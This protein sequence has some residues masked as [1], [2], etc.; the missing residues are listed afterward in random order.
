MFKC[1]SSAASGDRP[2]SELPVTKVSTST[3]VL[4]LLVW[5]PFGANREQQLCGSDSSHPEVPGTM[6]AW[7]SVWLAWMQELILWGIKGT[8]NPTAAKGSGSSWTSSESFPV[9]PAEW[10]PSGSLLL[11]KYQVRSLKHPTP[12][13]EDDHSFCSSHVLEEIQIFFSL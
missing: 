2:L 7:G 4:H 10:Q 1:V 12:V 5:A 6:S 13:P 8:T 3:W 11:P 9:M